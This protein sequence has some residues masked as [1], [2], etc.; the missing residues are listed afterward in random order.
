MGH[1]LEQKNSQYLFY[2]KKILMLKSSIESRLCNGY[3]T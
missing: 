3:D 2:P 1:P